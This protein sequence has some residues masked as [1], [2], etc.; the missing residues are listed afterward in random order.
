MVETA[1]YGSAAHICIEKIIDLCS[2]L[3]YLRV[4]VR[5]KNFMFGDNKSVV[6]SSMGLHAKLH[7]RHTMLSFH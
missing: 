7:K 4:P 3:R 5:E 2:T 6:D 1:T